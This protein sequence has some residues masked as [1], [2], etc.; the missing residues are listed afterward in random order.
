MTD[1]GFH[2]IQLDGKQL[3]FLFMATTVVSVVIFLCGVLVGRGVG[4]EQDAVLA[5]AELDVTP[6]STSIPD[7]VGDGVPAS[8]A[9]AEV[10][11]EDLTYPDRLDEGSPVPESIAE[12][13]PPEAA[14]EAPPAAEPMVASPPPPS[15]EGF[16]VQVA[17]LSERPEA[18]AMVQRLNGK[19]YEAYILDPAPNAPTTM[20][21][22]RVG[23][24]PDRGEAEQILRRLE[25][26]EQFKPWITR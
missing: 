11:A 22:V 5:V 6:S 7:A 24:Y 16:T 4:V 14:T 25:R 13:P 17:A 10:R 8:E 1:D 12:A 9:Q 2:E 26:E 3:V 18:E 15:A 23:R 21:R 20:F 19:G